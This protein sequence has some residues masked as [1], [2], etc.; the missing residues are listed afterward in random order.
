MRRSSG[1]RSTYNSAVFRFERRINNGWG[2]RLNYTLQQDQRTT[3]FRKTS[4]FGRVSRARVIW[5]PTISTRIHP[6]GQRPAASVQ[7]VGHVRVAVRPGQARGS[8]GRRGRDPRRLGSDCRRHRTPVATRSPIVPGQQ[9]HRPARQRA[10]PE[11]G[12]RRRSRLLTIPSTIRRCSCLRWLNPAAWSSAPAFTFGNAP[13]HRRPRAHPVQE[14]H[15]H[16][17]PEDSTTGRHEERD[18][19]ASR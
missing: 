1:A 15:G 8:T 6:V 9:Q 10:A 11:R 13:A 12:L 17:L 4:F 2:A 7:P 19:A 16:R 3:R 18:G 5:M 14:E